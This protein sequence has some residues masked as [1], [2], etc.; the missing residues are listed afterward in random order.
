MYL[1]PAMSGSRRDFATFAPPF[2]M[3]LMPLGD[4]VVLTTT[5]GEIGLIFGIITSFCPGDIESQLMYRGRSSS[6]QAHTG[7]NNRA[8]P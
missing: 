5:P 7:V 1:N 8:D 6:E 3:S 4:G 2:A